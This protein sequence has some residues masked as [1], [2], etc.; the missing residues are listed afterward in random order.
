MTL[1]EKREKA[2]IKAKQRVE[3]NNYYIETNC[4]FCLNKA[5]VK[6]Y[7]ESFYKKRGGGT[8]KE[9]QRRIS[10]ESLKKLRNSQTEEQK[11]NFAKFARS[12]VKSENIS[13]GVRK[14]WETF[15]SDP[16]KYKE[17]CNARSKRMEKVWE[18]YSDEQRNFIVKSLCDSN[19]CGRSKLSE[20]FKQE[21][22][23][24]NLYDG[25]KSE[26]IFHGFVPDEINENLKLIIEV[27]GDVYHCN[28]KKFKNPDVFINVIQRTVG[29]QWKRDEIKIAA[30]K[31]NGYEVLIVWESDI[32]KRLTETLEKV[33]VFIE[34]RKRDNYGLHATH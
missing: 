27:F 16:I 20:E 5:F 17:I 13:N 1:E 33:K 7:S 24:H 34:N 32:R 26:Q 3:Q 29:E 22:L 12:K 9:C 14:Q 15:R 21:L 28:P 18:N 30:Y 8:C 10:S 23:K 2:R 11:S 6:K 19:D 25:F 31:R 4:R